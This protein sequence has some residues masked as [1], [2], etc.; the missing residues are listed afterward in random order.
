MFRVHKTWFML[1]H[2]SVLSLQGNAHK[3]DLDCEESFKTPPIAEIL[4][5]KNG[6][7]IAVCDFLVK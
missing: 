2:V 3:H 4:C 5:V 6:R 1:K 7:V